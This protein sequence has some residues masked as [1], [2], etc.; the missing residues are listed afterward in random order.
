MVIRIK[1]CV[2][3]KKFK[4]LIGKI[5]QCE[6]KTVNKKKKYDTIYDNIFVWKYEMI[7]IQNCENCNWANAEIDEL[8]K[9]LIAKIPK[10]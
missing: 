4:H 3:K 8:W 9:Y 7:K 1:R 5:H 6:Q 2:E 10:C